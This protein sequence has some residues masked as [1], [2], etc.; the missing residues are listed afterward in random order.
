MADTA[1]MREKFYERIEQLLPNSRNLLSKE[2]Y[3]EKLNIRKDICV[4][5]LGRRGAEYS[6]RLRVQKHYAVETIIR[7]G[8]DL[9]RLRSAVSGKLFVHTGQLFDIIHAAHLQGGHGGR[10]KM[11]HDLKV[12]NYR[13]LFF[14]APLVP[15]LPNFRTENSTGNV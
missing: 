9:E 8:N 6:K 3:E 2:E 10:N 5:G 4:S 14:A 13:Q 15:F 11:E 12:E 1:T 7:E